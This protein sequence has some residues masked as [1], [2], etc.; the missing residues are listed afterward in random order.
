VVVPDSVVRQSVTSIPAFQTNG[1]FDKAKFTQILQ[2]NNSSPD[3]FLG[4]VRRD[5]GANQIVEAVV[6][7]VAPA[8]ELTNQIFAFVSEQ[9]S[10][11]TVDIAAASQPAPVLPGDAV[12]QRYWRNHQSAFSAPEY[13]EAKIVI[14][15]P[16]TLAPAQPVSAAEIQAAYAATYGQQVTAATRSVQVITAPDAASAAKLASL[17]TTGASWTAMQAAAAKAGGT[18]VELDNATQTQIPSPALA[19]AVF[20]AAPNTIGGP[21]QGPLGYFV[22]NVTSASAGG[23]PPLSTVAAQLKQQIQLQKARQQV[24][25]DVDNVQDALAGQAA[26]DQLPGNL[27]LV[28]VEGTLDANG[29]TPDGSPA[30]IPGGD[31]LRNAIIKAIF[32]AH[33]GDPAQLITGPDNGYFAFTLETITPPAVEP[34][35]SVKQKVAVEWIQDEMLREAEVKAATLLNAVNHGQSLDTVA[36]AAGYSVAMMPPVT[37]NAPPSG[38]SNEMVQI[39]FSLKQGQGT[40]LQSADG[41]TVAE[42]TTITK[43]TPQEDPADAAE[44]A[45]AMTKSLSDDTMASLIAGLQARD[46]VRVYPKLYAQIYQ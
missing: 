21:L 40:M 44:V 28:A 20:A 14:L 16:Q 39:L 24:N 25:Q 45:Q 12:L 13:R 8:A 35:G 6:A 11:E 17:W 31:A 19:S 23:A 30:P 38:V 34:Y 29:N 3:Q 36:S 9:R 18:G 2:Q 41:F 42:L 15:S 27:G 43:P 1:V 32:A 10:A 4:L 33:P 26:L 5:L 37:R 46:K 22:F 7:G